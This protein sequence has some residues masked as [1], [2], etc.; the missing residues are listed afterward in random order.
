MGTEINLYIPTGVKATNELFN[1]FCKAWVFSPFP[2]Y[3]ILIGRKNQTILVIIQRVV[4][5][6]FIY[7]LNE[8]LGKSQ[9]VAI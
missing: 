5:N 1:G 6:V 8:G 7:F 4:Y 2:F 3:I 9:V